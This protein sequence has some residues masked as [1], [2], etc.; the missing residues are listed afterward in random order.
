V[1]STN[2]VFVPFNS[3]LD[4]FSFH[5]YAWQGNILNN[6]SLVPFHNVV[7][8][9]Y[10]W[11]VTIL[12][13]SIIFFYK[14]IK[15]NHIIIFLLVSSL[16]GIFL[17]KQQNP[18]FGFIYVWL[19]YHLPT[20]SLFRESNKFIIFFLP[21]SLL[22]GFS[23]SFINTKFKK[24]ITKIVFLAIVAF[25]VLI[26][27]IPVINKQIGTLFVNH[28]M[29]NDYVILNNFL[30]N[31]TNYFRDIVVPRD[32]S[33]QAY[34]ILHPKISNVDIVG[35]NWSNFINYKQHDNDW[36]VQSQIVD[37]YNKN[38][39]NQL[40]DI[41]A[42]KYVIV[43]I[44][45]IAND[46]DAFF[47]YGGDK[48]PNIR[49]WYI[50]QLDKVKWL[51][52]IDIGT[53]DL[54]VYENE[55]FRDH[56]YTTDKQETIYKN[57]QAKNVDYQFINPTEYKIKLTNIA[58]ST[59]LNFSEAYHFDWSLRVGNFNWF[60]VLTDK[61][62]FFDGKYHFENDAHLNSFLIDPNY[63]K[64]N[65]DKSY[66][67]ENPDGSIDVELTLYF[68]PQSYFYLGIIISGT[69]LVGCFEYL[70]YD[71]VKRRKKRL[72]IKSLEKIG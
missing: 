35:G 14:K 4:S 39:S 1:A 52:K 22:F 40:F 29:S 6:F 16:I 64:Q 49:Q 53:K 15:I 23:I 10:F 43:P 17:L 55:D 8:S 2:N 69:T 32:S 3:L 71:F 62:Y 60:N 9:F 50:D 67:K 42:I 36:P 5:N 38:F 48:N 31:Q 70:G 59:Y 44:Q 19:F 13:F 61:N 37:I 47:P 54:V 51:K 65:F 66:Y 57:L 26:N 30:F 63:I 68:K 11:V 58:T 12:I 33:W 7:V 56:I 72:E 41:T 46:D 45:D 18:P 20:F 34:S 24:Q 25:I 28:N 27:V 21:I